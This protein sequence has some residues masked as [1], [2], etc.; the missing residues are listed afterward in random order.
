MSFLPI[1][2][3]LPH[4]VKTIPFLRGA[5]GFQLNLLRAKLAFQK[6]WRCEVEIEEVQKAKAF[7]LLPSM[8]PIQSRFDWAERDHQV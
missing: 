3:T 1:P 5:C 4:V 2:P 7:I 6:L 8:L